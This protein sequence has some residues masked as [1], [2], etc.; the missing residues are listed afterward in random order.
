MGFTKKNAEKF[1]TLIAEN[2]IQ[3]LIDI[4]LHNNT[5]LSG[6]TKGG[7]LSYF[8]KIICNCQYV[9]E[10]CFAPTKELLDGYKKNVIS[11][12][13]Y[14]CIYRKLYIQRRMEEHFNNHY[15]SY[16]R[17]LLLCSEPT[18]QKCHRRLLSEYLSVDNNDIKVVHL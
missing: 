5:Q 6:F 12:D 17:I 13:E 1:F 9:H 14:E 7:D 18:P 11:W 4:R 8:L 2:K 15:R 10:K 16:D 3:M